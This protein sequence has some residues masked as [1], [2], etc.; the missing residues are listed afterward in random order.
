MWRT[1]TIGLV[2]AAIV[3]TAG[4]AFAANSKNVGTHLHGDEEVPAR[5]TRAQGQATFRVNDDGTAIR[6]KLNVANIENVIMAHI[7]IAPPGENGG[8]VVWLYPSTT[9][10]VQD[11]PGGGRLQGPIAEGTIT[12]AN[13]V[14]DLAGHPLSDLLDA[15]ESGDAYVNVHTNDGVAPINTGPGDFPMGEIR[16]QLD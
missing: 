4:S 10:N 16:G 1:R 15:I 12:A 9:P 8:V 2:A 13:L 6:Y 11:P 5:P 7:H 14:G 3:L